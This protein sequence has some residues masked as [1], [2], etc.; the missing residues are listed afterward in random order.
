MAKELSSESK[1]VQIG[2][3]LA[4]ISLTVIAVS[5]IQMIVLAILLIMGK[6]TNNAIN[7]PFAIN[8]CMGLFGTTS[9]GISM[10]FLIADLIKS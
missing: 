3:L 7:L 2:L 9:L 6:T 4:I 10:I 1:L 5:T 8:V